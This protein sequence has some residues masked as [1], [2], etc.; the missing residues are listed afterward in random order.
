MRDENQ[1]DHLKQLLARLQDR[2]A[3]IGIVGL[4]YVGL[5]L[6]LR[7]AAEGFRV[8]GIDI[9]AGK[10]AALNRGASYIAHIEAETI[11]AAR[12]HGFSASTEFARAAEADALII[13]V[14]TPLSP[15]REPDLS[16]VLGTADALLPHMRAGQ[17]L[18]LES[19]TYPG[20]T[21]EELRPR[22]EQ[23]GF[24]V[25][26]DV[27]LVFSPEREDP[28]NPDFHTRTIPK[29]CGGSSAACLE[30]GLALYRQAIDTVVPVSSTRA[31][32]LTKLLE[33]IHRAVNIGLVNEMKIIAD[34]MG[35][36]IHEV[37]RAAATKPFGF[38]PYYPGPGLGGHCIPI[39]PFYLTWKARQ[40]GLHTRFIE[41]AG[42]INSDMPHWVIGKLADA[43]NARGRSI[44]GSRVLVLGTAYKKDV[45]DMRESPSVALMELLRDKGAHVDY[46]DPHVPVFPRMREHRFEL[47]SVTLSPTSI[48]SYDVVLLATAHSAFDYAL[49]RQYANLIVDT[50]GVYLERLPHVVK[51]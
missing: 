36:D 31:A 29:V 30:A 44:M 4:G 41:L 1:S 6:A 24:T 11:Q 35:I 37:I 14:P 47:S 25:G 27:F 50:R 17:I 26:R 49:I 42:E 38:T 40:Y 46:S 8:L 7:Y 19:T 43:L 9:D 20:T 2:S 28:G 45:E 16:Y 13:C 34:R 23:R 48:A 22:L 51:A 12:S 32:E 18:A 15:Y 3:V 21:E 33:N 39:D 10:V 5:P